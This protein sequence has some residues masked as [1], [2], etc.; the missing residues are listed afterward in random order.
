MELPKKAQVISGA[1]PKLTSGSPD[2][3]ELI[4]EEIYKE[5]YESGYSEAMRVAQQALQADKK[6]LEVIEM[7]SRQASNV[8]YSS[9]A[10]E[11]ITDKWTDLFERG[12]RGLYLLAPSNLQEVVKGLLGILRRQKVRGKAT[13]EVCA[14]QYQQLKEANCLAWGDIALAISP[15]LKVGQCR[16]CYLDVLIEH[17]R[18]AVQKELELVLASAEFIEAN[19]CE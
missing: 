16:I 18:E 3:K 6:A 9:E 19:S 13:I 11:S 8:C 10:L 5:G 17:D 7:I 2:E 15:E 12:F 1:F 4:K 14:L